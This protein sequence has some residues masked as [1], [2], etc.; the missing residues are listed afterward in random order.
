MAAKGSVPAIRVKMLRPTVPQS[1]R[2]RRTLFAWYERHGRSFP[3][4][5]TRNPY[6]VL[7]AELFL[8]KTQAKQVHPI[9]LE[10]LRKFPTLKSLARARAQRIKAAIWS[11]GLLGRARHLKE[12]AQMLGEKFDGRIPSTEAELL[13]LKGVGRYVANAVLCFAFDQRRA[14]VDANVVRLLSRYFGI[15]SRKDRA[16]TDS[17]MWEA[18]Q[19]LVPRRRVK[20]FNWGVFDFAA[21]VCTSQNPRCGQ[22][23]LREWCRW[24]HKK[25]GER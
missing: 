8:Q 3:W 18:A 17:F 16:H 15:K 10:F 12:M 24:P 21:L 1:Q 14:V 7:I 9:Y 23:V 22:C 6:R 2:F 4:R 5:E 11:L 13:Q 19:S 20:E 25:L